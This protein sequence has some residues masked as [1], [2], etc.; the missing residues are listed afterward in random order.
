MPSQ[1]W[2]GGIE[3]RF[4][5]CFRARL[6]RQAWPPCHFCNQAAPPPR[7]FFPARARA[8]GARTVATCRVAPVGHG[9]SAIFFARANQGAVDA[10]SGSPA[11][12][13]Q[14]PETEQPA[15]HLEGQIAIGN[16]ATH[17]SLG[18]FALFSSNANTRILL[19]ALARHVGRECQQFPGKGFGAEKRNARVEK[20]RARFSESPLVF[21]TRIKS[22][23]KKRAPELRDLSRV[24]SIRRHFDILR[25]LRSSSTSLPRVGKNF[26]TRPR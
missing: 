6:L 5:P 18:T 23:R 21:L 25:R 14:V 3:A 13:G 8:A 17:F 20:K 15:T 12:G 4:E 1:L 2:V 19:L 11:C 22:R 10:W 24:V 9:R 16:R 26:E 7:F